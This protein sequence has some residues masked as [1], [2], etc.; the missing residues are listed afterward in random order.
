[1]TIAEERIEQVS[2]RAEAT[3]REFGFGAHESSVILAL[4]QLE[5]ATVADLSTATGIHHANLYSVLEGLVSRGLVIEHEGRPRRFEFTP[6]SN[7]R[8]LLSTKL[9]Q[10]ILDMERIQQEREG[11]QLLPTLIYTIRGRSVV[12]SKMQGMV[13][14]ASERILLVT[15]SMDMFDEPVHAALR[16]AS[17]RGVS[18]RLIVAEESDTHDYE[19]EQRIREDTLAVNLVIDGA[20]AL[21]SMPDLSVCGWADNALI[22]LQLEGFL[23]QTWNM[24]R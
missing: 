8:D 24:S 20:E 19:V 7:V 23:E 6:L 9:D 3:L 5:S 14:R 17:E 1:M 4:N 11:K 2:S 15:P 22:S 10:L 16:T 13:S 18:I 12:E 21:I